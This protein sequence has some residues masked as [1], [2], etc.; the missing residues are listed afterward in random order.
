MMLLVQFII[1]QTKAGIYFGDLFQCTDSALILPFIPGGGY[2]Y[3][4]NKT[5]YKAA[6]NRYSM[7]SDD[8]FLSLKLKRYNKP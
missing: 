2:D 6:R 8:A 3:R 4:F 5:V 7:V 1:V